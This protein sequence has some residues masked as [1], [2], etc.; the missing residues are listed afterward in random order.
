MTDT[1][2]PAISTATNVLNQEMG[3]ETMLLNLANESYCG[4]D[5]IVIRRYALAE[6][7]S[8]QAVV[9]RLLDECEISAEQLWNDVQELIGQWTVAGL[10]LISRDVAVTNFK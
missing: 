5:E 3:S 9:A 2:Q 6:T 10:A 1:W 8:V 4:F 7:R